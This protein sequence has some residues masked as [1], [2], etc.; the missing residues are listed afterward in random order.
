MTEE[1]F[2]MLEA[3]VNPQQTLPGHYHTVNPYNFSKPAESGVCKVCQ[4][5]ANY[6][7]GQ[8]ATRVNFCTLHAPEEFGVSEVQR[9]KETAR[10]KRMAEDRIVRA[11]VALVAN[12]CIGIPEGQCKL[13]DEIRNAVQELA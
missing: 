7:L 13:C 5:P 10:R 2:K 11:A 6:H 3:R 1:E 4:F 9:E 12:K 8:G